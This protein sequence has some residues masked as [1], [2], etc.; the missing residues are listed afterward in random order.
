MSASKL[1]KLLDTLLKAS[2]EDPYPEYDEK[3]DLLVR[4][5]LHRHLY[6]KD[7][8]REELYQNISINELRIIAI[9]KSVRNVPRQIK[10]ATTGRSRKKYQSL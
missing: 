7:N 8:T 2:Q 6:G 3:E 5:L 4:Y 9:R 1:E 10:E